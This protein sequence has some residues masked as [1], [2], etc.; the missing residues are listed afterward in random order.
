MKK[1]AGP[2]SSKS[3]KVKVKKGAP[4]GRKL[5]P[6]QVELLLAHDQHRRTAATQRERH[7]VPKRPHDT[8][9]QKLEQVDAPLDLR[10]QQNP[11][12]PVVHLINH[13]YPTDW[14]KFK[15][16]GSSLGV[17]GSTDGKA[18]RRKK[19]STTAAVRSAAPMD[20]GSIAQQKGVP[21]EQCLKDDKSDQKGCQLTNV[22]WPLKGLCSNGTAQYLSART[23][24]DQEQVHLGTLNS[25]KSNSMNR[26][27]GDIRC[28]YGHVYMLLLHLSL[29]GQG[30]ECSQTCT[31]PW[32]PTCIPVILMSPT[33]HIT[34]AR[35]LYRL[36]QW[37]AFTFMYAAWAVHPLCLVT[38]YFSLYSQ[39]S[40]AL[41]LHYNALRFMCD[42]QRELCRSGEGLGTQGIS[43][44][45]QPLPVSQVPAVSDAREGRT[46]HA[47]SNDRLQTQTHDATLTNKPVETAKGKPCKLPTRTTKRAAA[48]NAIPAIVTA[49]VLDFEE[50]SILWAIQSPSPTRDVPTSGRKRRLPNVAT[51]TTKCGAQTVQKVTKK[52]ARCTKSA[53]IVSEENSHKND[54]RK[55]NSWE[56][57][58]AQG[59]GPVQDVGVQGSG[60]LEASEMQDVQPC[61]V[62]DSFPAGPYWPNDSSCWTWS[63]SMNM[64]FN[65]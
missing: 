29:S 55:E 45:L 53:M 18:Y 47:V 64:D 20:T 39:W 25:Y 37:D 46:E 3:G 51:G 41:G 59:Q 7:A 38:D 44:P 14:L 22:P 1:S 42:K 2:A 6:A 12:A 13:K 16:S 17:S 27:E 54:V 65:V 48:L 60:C 61:E 43:K 4:K 34:I 24:P 9:G 58:L 40:C 32:V 15:K 63:E 10:R 57:A 11:D 62:E 8:P 49:D 52:A 5:T 50:S 31:D 33:K 26:A 21:F 30:V 35:T 23:E 36:L 28:G 56:G 19:H